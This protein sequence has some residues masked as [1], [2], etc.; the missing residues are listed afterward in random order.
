[1]V[2][3]NLVGAPEWKDRRAADGRAIT[4]HPVVPFLFPA[5]QQHAWLYVFGGGYSITVRVCR[6]PFST[7]GRGRVR[8]VG[9][10]RSL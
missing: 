2:Q 8:K 10:W 6:E 9:E 3:I 5:N 1:M 7:G 4:G